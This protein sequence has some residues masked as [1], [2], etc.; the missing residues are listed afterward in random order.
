K[1][2]ESE[3]IRRVESGSMPLGGP[4]LPQNELKALRA[5]VSAGAPDWTPSPVARP[6]PRI[7]E[8]Q[9]LTAVLEDVQRSR[10]EERQSLRYLSLANLNN[11]PEVTAERFRLY[12]VALSKLVNSLSW[13]HRIAV[14]K[15]F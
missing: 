5:W 1:P 13:N 10:P 6:R 7:T 9:V 14:P 11:N 12:D 2:D 3:L 15:A 4:K 8:A